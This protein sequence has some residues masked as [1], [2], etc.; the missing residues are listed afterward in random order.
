MQPNF[1]FD[2]APPQQML[3]GP[4]PADCRP[5][6][7]GRPEKYSSVAARNDEAPSSFK[8]SLREAR[9]REREAGGTERTENSRESA[10]TRTGSCRESK[11][12]GCADGADK[13]ESPSEGQE[14]GER[15]A[16]GKPEDIQEQPSAQDTEKEEQADHELSGAAAATLVAAVPDVLPAEAG[17]PS[18]GG[19]GSPDIADDLKPQAAESEPA[20]LKKAAAGFR[21]PVIASASDKAPG[22]AASGNS[23]DTGLAKN[24]A[25]DVLQTEDARGKGADDP[26]RTRDDLIQPDA[27]SKKTG[28]AVAGGQ[29]ATDAAGS[30]KSTPA[31]QAD[32]Q[33]RLPKNLMADQKASVRSATDTNAS[34]HEDRAA[35]RPGQASTEQPGAGRVPG[36]LQ[37]VRDSDGRIEPFN[38]DET[39]TKLAKVSAGSK[40]TAFMH[41]QDQ[42]FDRLLESNSAT[43]GKEGPA[44]AWRA[45]TLDQIVSKAVYQ[46]KNGQNSVRIDLKPEFLGQVRMQIVTVEQQVSVRIITELPMVKEMLDNH[47]QQLKADLQQQGLDVDEIEVSVSTDAQHNARNR[48]TPFEEM[49]TENA[50]GGEDALSDGMPTPE[51]AAATRASTGSVDM[52]V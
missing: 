14:N 13:D 22:G 44:G 40:D 29:V 17:A 32:G 1:A 18:T 23:D 47:L 20:S 26:V 19:F 4:K 5:P 39:G 6:K 9:Q 3:P 34:S 45:Q 43:R 27:G 50:P 21:D 30:Q 7:P 28:K 31:D 37:Q 38:G 48:R 35:A 42:S 33:I 24:G 41:Q 2:P 15:A 36:D 51:A 25:P 8:S 10:E 46:L 12:S 49:P 16:D 52:F 11:N